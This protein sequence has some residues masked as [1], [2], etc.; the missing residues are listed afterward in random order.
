MTYTESEVWAAFMHI[1][2]M[3]PLSRRAEAEITF[4]KALNKGKGSDENIRE[5]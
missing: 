4:E 2:A 1:I 3:V 5:A